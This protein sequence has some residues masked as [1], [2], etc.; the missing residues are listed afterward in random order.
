ML[1]FTHAGLM[2]S[3]FLLMV[4]GMAAARYLRGKGWWLKAHRRLVLGGF[5]AVILGFFAEA[6][7]LSLDGNSHFTVPHAHLGVL[8]FFLLGR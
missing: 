4:A 5:L 6:L 8:I 7:Q 2:V 1:L 3:G